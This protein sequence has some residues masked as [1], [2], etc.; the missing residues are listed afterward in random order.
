ME[1]THKS[2]PVSMHRAVSLEFIKASG[3]FAVR[4][5]KGQKGPGQGWNPTANDLARSQK[6]IKELEN[7]T[8]DNIGIHLHGDLV[9]VDIDSDSPALAHALDAFLPP[10][11]HTWG[12][13]S[14]PRTH[15]VYK[16]QHD[17]DP[18]Q[19]P[20]L[21]RIKNMP[22]VKLELR[23]GRPGRGMYSVLPGSLHPS[24]EEYLWTDLK[25]ARS[26]LTVVPLEGILRAMR[27]AGAVSLLSPH[28]IEGQRNDMCLA[29]SG[30]L[31][32]VCSIAE[33]LDEEIFRVDK[34]D[35]EKLLI[36][37]MDIAGDDQADRR[38]RMLTFEQTWSK[39]ERDS[40]VTGATTLAKI[41]GDDSLITALY[42]LLCE[43]PSVATLD[44]FVQSFAVWMGRGLIIDL[45]KA[46][47]NDPKSFMNRT[48]FSISYADK[49]IES[50]DKRKLAT[51][52]FIHLPTITRV[53]G[54]TFEPGQER[55]VEYSGG[56][57]RKVNQWGGFRVAPWDAPVTEEEVKPFLVY[58]YEIIAASEEEHFQWVLH[59][60]AHI[61]KTPAQR[62]GTALVLVGLPGTGKS[63]LGE[64]FIVPMIGDNYSASTSSVDRIVSGFNASFA[65][66]LF[67]QCDEAI[68][69]RQRQT[70]AKL[71]ALITDPQIRIEPKGIDSYSLPNHMRLFFTSNEVHDAVF[72]SDG[73]DDR[74]YTVL[75]VSDI[76]KNDNEAYWGPLAEWANEENLSKIHRYLV[77]LPYQHAEITRPLITDAKIAVQSHSMPAFDR[78]LAT[79][80]TRDHPLGTDQHLAWFDTWHSG[81]SQEIDRSEWPEMVNFVALERD[82]AQ[83][84][85]SDPLRA[86][87]LNPHQIHGEFSERGF[88]TDATKRLTAEYFDDRK[89]AQ[90]IVRPRLYEVPTREALSRYLLQKYGTQYDD[91]VVETTTVEEGGDF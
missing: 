55:F 64:H 50:G 82:Y 20:V 23:G 66:K 89:N 33:G 11:S 51:D 80:V 7:E 84:I 28:W 65:N 43:S 78:W 57:E 6:L 2:E 54:F 9:D 27:L 77:D 37:L 90:V 68:S 40:P 25:R 53:D 91:R 69:N 41:A 12:R 60:I 62:A 42:S 83:F 3:G 72:L 8:Q 70:A 71:K 79:M 75:K 76:H 85:R 5:V 18:E 30:F 38:A 81:M 87:H 35:A 45:R 24:G 4:V 86:P 34:D 16:L 36:T 61:F 63:F 31:Q 21:R 32:R 58:L 88:H 56:D 15:R 59:W 1:E 73:S 74:R 67:V 44:W 10:C 48:E 26:T 17:F 52:V 29:L 22:D 49:F 13:G 47:R 19:V 14:R 46:M 39:G